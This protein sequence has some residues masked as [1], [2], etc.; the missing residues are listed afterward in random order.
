MG[1]RVHTSPGVT[2]VF[3][4]TMLLLGLLA[5][6]LP[7]ETMASG[8]TC[9][10]ACCAARAPHAAGSCLNHSCHAVRTSRDHLRERTTEPLCRSTLVARHV[11]RK[12]SYQI[13]FSAESQPP[14]PAQLYSSTVSKTC[15]SDCGSCAG[16]ENTVRQ[17]NVALTAHDQ[18]PEPLGAIQQLDARAA[19]NQKRNALCRQCAPRAPPLSLS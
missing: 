3:L 4:A 8:P 13:T 6:V 11:S 17:R 9:A 5:G 2:R 1:N 7:L 15:S 14:T 18:Q 16:F 10:L 12:R 19:L